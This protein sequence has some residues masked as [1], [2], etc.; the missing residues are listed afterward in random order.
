MHWVRANWPS[1]SAIRDTTVASLSS[2]MSSASQRS[3]WSGGTQKQANVAPRSIAVG[4]G[5]QAQKYCE[6]KISTCKYNVCTFFPRFLLEQFRRY[7]NVFF[8]IIAVLQQIPEVSPTGHYTTAVPF[9]FILSGSALKEIF[10]DIKRRR[11]DSEVNNYEVELLDSFGSVCAGGQIRIAKWKEL[12]VGQIIR[13]SEGQFFPADIVL[14]SSSEALG[15]AYI[16][17]AQLD[18]ETNLK[19]RQAVPLTAQLTDIAQLSA[20]R[21]HIECEPPNRR[22]HEFSGTMCAGDDEKVPLSIDQFLLRGAK[23]K[24]CR[25]VFGV[26]VYTGHD[27]RLLMNSTSAR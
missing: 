23:L 19:I 6:N 5:A 12:R 1:Y 21:A 24:N 14:L 15:M 7:S 2:S 26:V 20:L 18:G 9:L 17:T 10:E 13:V 22:V 16:E 25:W 4:G 8:L 11:M 27:S 3:T